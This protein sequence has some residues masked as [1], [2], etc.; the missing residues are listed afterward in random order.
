MKLYDAIEKR[1]TVLAF[2]APATVEQLKRITL[3]GAKAPSSRNSQ[4]WEFILVED[5]GLIEK[6]ARIKYD[7]SVAMARKGGDSPEEAEKRAA[8]QKDS[9][10]NASVL[11][12]CHAPRGE[13][14]CWLAVEN[15]SLAAVAENL[16]TGIVFYGSGEQ[17]AEVGGLLN[18]PEGMALTCILKIG[19]PDRTVPPRSKTLR[20]AYSWLHR[21]TYGSPL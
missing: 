11:A 17:G 7:M 6:I 5:A 13:A 1:S 4:P 8:I 18:L 21:N 14:S 12:V 2:N 15:I 9:F 16:G 20:P 19:V 10:R 3:A